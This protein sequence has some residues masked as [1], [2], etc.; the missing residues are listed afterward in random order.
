MQLPGIEAL[1]GMPG[2]DALSGLLMPPTGE[3]VIE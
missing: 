3:R 1:L 2:D